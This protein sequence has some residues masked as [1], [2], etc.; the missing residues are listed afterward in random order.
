ML[1]QGGEQDFSSGMLKVL[2]A[3]TSRVS[4]VSLWESLLSEGAVASSGAAHYI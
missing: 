1:L 2:V 4:A 3:G